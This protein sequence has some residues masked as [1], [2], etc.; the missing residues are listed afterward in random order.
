MGDPLP[1]P[2]HFLFHCQRVKTVPVGSAMMLNDRYPGISATSLRT[3]A[4]KKAADRMNHANVPA[5]MA[6]FRGDLLLAFIIID[7]AHAASFFRNV[8]LV[9]FAHV[10]LQKRV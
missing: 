1:C 6:R 7:V 8:P 4:P 2:L 9:Y 10:R 3:F 5:R